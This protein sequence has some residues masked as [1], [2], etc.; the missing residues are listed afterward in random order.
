MTARTHRGY[1]QWARTYDSDPNPHTALEYEAV[2]AAVSA[3]AGDEIL[4]AA[5]GTGRYASRFKADRADVVGMDFSREM[6]SHAR[7]K[8]TDI[9]LV[10]ADLRRRLPFEDDRFTKINCAQALKH[11]EHLAPT[12]QEFARVLRPGGL[13]VFSVT[14]P[15]MDWDGYELAESPSF[16][17]SESSDI[18][19]HRFEDYERAL[20]RAGLELLEVV[21]VRVSET[22][23]QLLTEASFEAVRGRPQIAVFK[24]VA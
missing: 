18:F 10:E 14:H 1:E 6:L 8:L 12:M 2:V 16:L 24:A 15:D 23:A 21:E 9:E 19:H 13:L 3:G 17:L 20:R 7:E 22:I 5:C 11:L 4:D